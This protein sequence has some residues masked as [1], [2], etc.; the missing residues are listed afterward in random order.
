VNSKYILKCDEVKPIRSF[1]AFQTN[2]LPPFYWLKNKL[3]RQVSKEASSNPLLSACLP[4]YSL[5]L[6]MK[7]ICSSDMLVNLYQT[8]W[9]HIPEDMDTTTNTSYFINFMVSAS[10]HLI[11]GRKDEIH[12]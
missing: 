11:E 3:S 1:L 8:T 5:T 6:K 10:T 12:S 4:S 9:C 2:V 7:A